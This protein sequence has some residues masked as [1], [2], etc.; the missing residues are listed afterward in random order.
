M[1]T[2]YLP[3]R[4]VRLTPLSG[5]EAIPPDEQSLAVS[6]T[7][8]AHGYYAPVGYGLSEPDARDREAFI[9]LA[10][11][12]M[13]I[14]GCIALMEWGHGSTLRQEGGPEHGRP[15][16]LENLRRIVR[17]LDRGDRL[18]S[19]RHWGARWLRRQLEQWEEQASGRG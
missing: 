16:D 17:C 7:S 1:S 19:E 5:S 8:L 13:T 10:A 14:F 2:P 3:H 4:C 18:P 11:D 6:L 15:E 12:V 9:A